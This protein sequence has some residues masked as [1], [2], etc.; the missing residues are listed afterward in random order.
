MSKRRQEGKFTKGQKKKY[1][2]VVL[3]VKHLSQKKPSHFKKN[4]K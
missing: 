2:Q 4:I 1:P 3:S